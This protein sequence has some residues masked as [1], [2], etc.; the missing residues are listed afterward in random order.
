MNFYCK[1]GGVETN[2]PWNNPTDDKIRE[3][4]DSL[5]FDL[6]NWYLVGN[7]IER[8]SKTWD[9]DIML[10]QPQAPRL[11]E[12][13]SNFTEMLTKGFNH[14]LLIDCAWMP[15]FYQ[16]EWRVIEKLRPDVRFEK[17]WNGEWYKSEY[18]ADEVKQVH[19]QVWWFKWNSPH[20]NWK[21]GIERNYN[22][23]GIPL[24]K[25]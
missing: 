2:T 12:L 24:N 14:Q 17:L 11:D 9:V 19:P 1:F 13:S 25:F 16:R 22:F 20:N 5:S 10:I 18:T 21:K 15:E 4:R 3:W 6:T 23:T 8:Y 7:V